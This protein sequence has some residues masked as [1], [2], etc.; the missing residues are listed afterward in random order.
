MQHRPVLNLALVCVASLAL[1]GS[2]T[3]YG[4]TFRTDVQQAPQP[5]ASL[6]LREMPDLYAL[7]PVVRVTAG[8]RFDPV[9]AWEDL[10]LRKLA[11]ESE[12]FRRRWRLI[13]VAVVRT[14]Q[15]WVPKKNADGTHAVEL[16]ERTVYAVFFADNRRF[17]PEGAV[18]EGTPFR[19]KRIVFDDTGCFVEVES[20]SGASVRVPMERD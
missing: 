3:W 18:L 10:E 6:D 13:G 19:I 14:D 5:A 9:Q 8:G 11:R 7:P 20:D 15:D 12:E 1:I 17:Y 4:L 16:V 2:A